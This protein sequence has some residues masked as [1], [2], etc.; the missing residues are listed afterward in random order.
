MPIRVVTPQQAE[1]A[2]AFAEEVIAEIARVTP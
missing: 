2:I 1:D